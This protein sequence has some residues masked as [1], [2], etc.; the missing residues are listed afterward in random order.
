MTPG[1]AV[2]GPVPAKRAGARPAA[3]AG[4]LPLCARGCLPVRRRAVERPTVLRCRLPSNPLCSP[5]PVAAHRPSHGD[6]GEHDDGREEHAEHCVERWGSP[7]RADQA[8][9]CEAHPPEATDDPGASQ[10]SGTLW[11]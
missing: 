6:H 5:G 3:G 1:T 7:T 2:P 10:P 9:L 8:D 11:R 4:R